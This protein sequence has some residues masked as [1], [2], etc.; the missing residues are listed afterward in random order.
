MPSRSPAPSPQS[1]DAG[2]ANR[3][4]LNTYA[5]PEKRTPP[6]VP[7]VNCR[8]DPYFLNFR[9]TYYWNLSD[10]NDYTDKAIIVY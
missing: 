6:T 2:N 5:R 7:R 10:N 1:A 9:Y 4:N 3:S 8:L